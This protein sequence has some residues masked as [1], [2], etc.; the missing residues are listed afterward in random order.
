[1]LVVGAG[2]YNRGETF[3]K[4]SDKKDP[5]SGREYREGEVEPQIESR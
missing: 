2:K 5:Q 1:M 3:I 4:L